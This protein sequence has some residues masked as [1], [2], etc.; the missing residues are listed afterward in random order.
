MKVLMILIWLVGS[1]PKSEVALFETEK[2][3]VDYGQA[4]ITRLTEKNE[5]IQGVLAE[6]WEIPVQEA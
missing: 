4:R 6:C 5:G 1:E 2:D 3:C